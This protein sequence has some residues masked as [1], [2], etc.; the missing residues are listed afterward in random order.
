MS[1]D[2][3]EAE[4]AATWRLSDGFHFA[5]RDRELQSQPDGPAAAKGMAVTAIGVQVRAGPR[6]DGLTFIG[7]ISQLALFG[8]EASSR[9]EI[10]FTIPPGQPPLAALL[11]TTLLIVVLWIV[12]AKLSVQLAL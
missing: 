3:G 9:G 7:G 6:L 12:S 10:A 2:T 8:G 1:A 5:H 4:I 11:D